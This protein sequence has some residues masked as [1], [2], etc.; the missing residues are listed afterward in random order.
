MGFNDTYYETCQWAVQVLPFGLCLHSHPRRRC[1]FLHLSHL[2]RSQLFLNGMGL[3][4][5]TVWEGE[6]KKKWKEK[7]CE[8]GEQVVAAEDDSASCSCCTVKS[9]STHLY[10]RHLIV[11]YRHNLQRRGASIVWTRF[12]DHR[13]RYFHT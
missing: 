3:S 11:C 5:A 4:K 13:R 12:V 10:N 6:Q 8:R 1:T 9:F 7:D 2:A